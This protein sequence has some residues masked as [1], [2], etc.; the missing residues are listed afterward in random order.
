M[1]EPQDLPDDISDEALTQWLQQARA[2]PDPERQARF[3]TELAEAVAQQPQLSRTL[4]AQ[5]WYRASPWALLAAGLAVVLLAL[6]VWRSDQD[7]AQ[8]TEPMTFGAAPPS[9]ARKAAT[10]QLEALSADRAAALPG[11]LQQ[12]MAEIPGLVWQHQSENTW[13][14]RVPRDQKSAFEQRLAAWSV[15]YHLELLPGSESPAGRA[16]AYHLYRLVPGPSS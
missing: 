2:V 10:P 15:P 11:P 12:H 13:L 1:T 16:A 9:A 8:Q 14:V 5:A 3:L 4:S 6:P 7:L